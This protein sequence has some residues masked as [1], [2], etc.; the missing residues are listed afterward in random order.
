MEIASGGAFQECAKI[1]RAEK[2]G[3]F[4]KLIECQDGQD[5]KSKGR[6]GHKIKHELST[7]ATLKAKV[8]NLYFIQSSK[9]AARG[10]SAAE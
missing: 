7:I 6:E 5:R 3:W 2:P 1:L 4:Q 9:K 10:L 8:R